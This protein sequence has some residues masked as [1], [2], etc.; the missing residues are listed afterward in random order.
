M[1]RTSPPDRTDD[2][3]VSAPRPRGG[4][5][6]YRLVDLSGSDVGGVQRDQPLRADDVVSVRSPRGTW[7]VVAVL[8]TCATVVPARR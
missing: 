7:R 8:G 3:A 6:R 2:G 4:R 5:F 1:E